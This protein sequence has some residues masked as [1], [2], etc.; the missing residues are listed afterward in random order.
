M[1]LIT[2]ATGSI[3]GH[4]VRRLRADRVPFRAL[5][6]DEA[7]GRAL[8]CDF[9][10]GD[11]DAPDTVEAAVRG[12]DRVLLNSAGAVPTDGRQPMVAQ[13][14]T[15]IDAGRKAGV[16][17]VVKVSVWHAR[18]G[19]RL[20]QGAHWEI[21][22]YLRASGL[23]WSI[24][25]PSGFM[26]NFV[27]GAGTFSADGSLIGPVPDA[28]TSYIDC[29]DIAACAAAV[30][31]SPVGPGQTHILTGP[32]ALTMGDIARTLTRLLGRPVHSVGLPPEAMAA[33]LREQGL[34]AAFAD[35]VAA[36]WAFVGTGAQAP[37][38]TAVKDLTGH[39]PRTFEQFVADNR[40][41]FR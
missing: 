29:Q 12:V 19:G 32:E 14:K 40:E 27:T 37:T 23:A 39:P 9:V 20:A 11:F 35:D 13:Q 15:V 8:G 4:L 10:V 28:P 34:P 16:A 2:G 6:R 25:Q 7:K 26:Q 17:Q 1:I 30:L 5:V 36:L 38:T 33:R 41:A 31:T 22:R 18:R 24:L 21:E 3:G